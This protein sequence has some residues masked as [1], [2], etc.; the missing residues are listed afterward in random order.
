MVKFPALDRAGVTS[1][2]GGVSEKNECAGIPGVNA[3]R[4]ALIVN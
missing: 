3:K 2:E 1:I 4:K